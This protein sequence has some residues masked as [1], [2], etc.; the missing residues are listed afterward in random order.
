MLKVAITKSANKELRRLPEDTAKRIA[1]KILA[2]A[3]NP[4]APSSNVRRLR[5]RPAYRLRVGKW[6]VI[7]EIHAD[8]LTVVAVRSRGGAYR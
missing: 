1:E 8:S 2:V 7:Y 4:H 6:R 3:A 5:G